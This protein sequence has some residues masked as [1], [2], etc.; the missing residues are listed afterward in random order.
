MH[1]RRLLNYCLNG[2]I[3]A[4]VCNRWE[5]LRGEA[6]S[7]ILLLVKIKKPNSKAVVV[8]SWGTHECDLMHAW[9]A[10]VRACATNALTSVIRS[11]AMKPNL[12]D[13]RFRIKDSIV[14]GVIGVSDKI[15]AKFWFTRL[16]IKILN[17]ECDRDQ[18][19]L[20]TITINNNLIVYINLRYVIFKY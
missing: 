20:F 16:E 6:G 17:I 2:S 4:V 19:K 7:P 18:F 15:A 9:R 3:M 5:E 12:P 8:P 11:T 10:C 1:T 14:V 13:V